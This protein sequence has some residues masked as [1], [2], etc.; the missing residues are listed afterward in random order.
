MSEGTPLSAE[1]A[2]VKRPE[3]LP[4]GRFG[5]QQLIRETWTFATINCGF[6][7]YDDAAATIA[8]LSGFRVGDRLTG[9]E[10]SRG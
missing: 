5:V 2:R 3:Y 9:E 4:G 6:A 8:G 7:S 1:T 10:A